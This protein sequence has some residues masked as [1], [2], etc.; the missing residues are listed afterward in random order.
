MY[1]ELVRVVDMV[2]LL[3]LFPFDMTL[4]ALDCGLDIGVP[5][6]SIERGGIEGAKGAV[7]AGGLG[8]EDGGRG[9]ADGALGAAVGGNRGGG[10]ADAAGR[11]GGATGAEGGAGGRDGADGALL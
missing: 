9:G 7:T 1:D 8:A 2:I 5:T 6:S 4:G 10:G 3:D 11:E